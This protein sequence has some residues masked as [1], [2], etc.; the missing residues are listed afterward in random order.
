MPPRVITST[1]EAGF[2]P[3]K[4]GKVR[5]IFDCGD[6]FL[7]VATDRLSAFDVILPDGIPNKGKV[8]TQ[9][10]SFWFR[11]LSHVVPTHVIS[12]DLKDFPEPFRSAPEVFA[13]RSM[14]VKKAKTL[15]V[16]CVVRGYISGS[17]WNDYKKTQSICGIALPAGLNESDRLPQPIFTPSTKEEVGTHDQNISFD[18]AVGIVGRSLAEQIRELSLRI[19]TEGARYAE[20][21][22]IIIAD[23]KFEFGVDEAGKLLWIDEA[24]TPDS[25]RFWPIDQYRPGGPQPSYDK[26]YVR[27]F[28][29]E[30]K[31]TKTPPAPRLPEKV[32]TTTAQKY[33]EALVQLTGNR[34]V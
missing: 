4:Q 3:T 7:I 1:A 15:P 25:S 10:S 21:R 29:L 6:R 14:L 13:G 20:T 27:D 31:W 32:I 2:K 11:K 19:Y 23:T 9:I 26:Q 17:G 18:Q 8:L 24:L 22:G 5:D 30:I 16:E 34:L 33:E 12:T 28:L